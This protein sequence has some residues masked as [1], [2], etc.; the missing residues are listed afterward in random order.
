MSIRRGEG[1]ATNALTR[2][3]LLGLEEKD[4]FGDLGEEEEDGEDD[5][6]EEKAKTAGIAEEAA[7]AAL[8]VVATDLRNAIS[9]QQ[10]IFLYIRSQYAMHL[11]RA[12]SLAFHLTCF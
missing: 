8:V 9:L 7:I 3:N 1:G 4:A 12:R 10:I 11:P 2:V 5:D 6:G